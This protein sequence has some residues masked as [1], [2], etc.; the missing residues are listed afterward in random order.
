MALWLPAHELSTIVEP[1]W[2]CLDLAR[3]AAGV[4]R[5]GEI[6]Q[7]NVQKS[8]LLST[9]LDSSILFPT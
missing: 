5:G 1:P 8:P 9:L 6:R 2:P 3:G 4:M 7:N